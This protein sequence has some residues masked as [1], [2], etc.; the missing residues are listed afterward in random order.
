VIVSIYDAVQ[1]FFDKNQEVIFHASDGIHAI[2]PI[3]TVI[4]NDAIAGLT[5]SMTS[6]QGRMQ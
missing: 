1:D 3:Q 5:G 6:A 2:K 4:S